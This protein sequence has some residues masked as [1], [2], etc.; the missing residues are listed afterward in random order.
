M[1]GEVY[2][3]WEERKSAGSPNILILILSLCFSSTVWTIC[4]YLFL[5][6]F[7]KMIG[8]Q[9]IH[10]PQYGRI[11]WSCTALQ[12]VALYCYIY[13]AHGSKCWNATQHQLQCRICNADCRYLHIADAI[14]DFLQ[15]QANEEDCDAPL[16]A[17][18]HIYALHGG[19]WSVHCS[20]LYLIELVFLALYGGTLFFGSVCLELYSWSNEHYYLQCALS[21]VFL[22][23]VSGCRGGGDH[24]TV[25]L[26][27]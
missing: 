26:E 1:V 13:S 19:Y 25:F 21:S 12:K 9:A 5:Y 27:Q 2:L 7:L 23:L 14:Y 15:R 24:G 6:S 8:R 3:E 20:H 18:M 4:L 22:N 16:C 17:A 10:Q 11:Y